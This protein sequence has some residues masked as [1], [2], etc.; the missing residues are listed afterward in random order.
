[1]FLALENMCVWYDGK[2]TFCC[3]YCKFEDLNS[4]VHIQDYF[5]ELVTLVW[6]NIILFCMVAFCKALY[7]PRI[8]IWDCVDMQVIAT[9]LY[10]YCP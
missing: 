6:W 8:K 7:L 1:M 5:S 4:A 9:I 3:L 10:S 2:T